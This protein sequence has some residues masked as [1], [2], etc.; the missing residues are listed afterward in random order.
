MPKHI[1]LLLLLASCL[2][3]LSVLPLA[4]AADRESDEDNDNDN[5][6]DNDDDNDG[7]AEVEVEKDRSQDEKNP[8]ALGSMTGPAAASGSPA[9]SFR[10]VPRS[11]R[12]LFASITAGIQMS[13]KSTEKSMFTMRT[14]PNLVKRRISQSSKK[15]AAPQVVRH[16]ART[17]PPTSFSAAT[18]PAPLLRSCT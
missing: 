16:P 4:A 13:A 12:V 2:A 8:P 1:L 11:H 5:D 3:L 14:W 17:A 18:T 7:E 9:G 15:P 10:L 6:K